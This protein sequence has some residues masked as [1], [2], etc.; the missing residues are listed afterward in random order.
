MKHFLKTT[1]F[2]AAI[3]LGTIAVSCGKGQ[4]E[5][6]REPS[7]VSIEKGAASP[8]WTPEGELVIP[9]ARDQNPMTATTTVE[10]AAQAPEVIKQEEAS[11]EDSQTETPAEEQTEE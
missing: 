2:L 10:E 11:A 1:A 9:D 4:E 5:G 8:M 7:T 6:E 3:S